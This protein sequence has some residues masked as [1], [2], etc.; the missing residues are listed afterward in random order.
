MRAIMKKKLLFLKIAVIVI[1]VLETIVLA[2]GIIVN[3][4]VDINSSYD[5]IK[6]AYVI[7]QIPFNSFMSSNSEISFIYD[8]I[9]NKI[10]KYPK[11]VPN[12]INLPIDSLSDAIDNDE[13]I[14]IEYADDDNYENGIII[15][16]EPKAGAA[17]DDGIT[18][19]LTINRKY[20]SINSQWG[21]MSESLG[22][23]YFLT[24]AYNSDSGT[25]WADSEKLE[26][27]KMIKLYVDNGN[28]YYN[29][30]G[31]VNKLNEKGALKVLER[32]SLILNYA[33]LNEGIY[34]ID[35]EDG[36]LYHHN[37]KDKTNLPV[38]NMPVMLFSVNTDYIMC[39]SPHDIFVLDA[40]SY[41][42][43]KSMHYK[44]IITGCSLDNDNVYILQY[45]VDD[46]N[47]ESREI[48]KYNIKEDE[49]VTIF[50]SNEGVSGLFAIDDKI[51]FIQYFDD[52]V[53]FR[54]INMRTMEEKF[55]IIKHYDILDIDINDILFDGQRVIYKSDLAFYSISIF[56]GEI[57]KID[58]IS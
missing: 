9:N 26:E 33:V 41:K 53:G 10:S 50:E 31:G 16:Q 57:K 17:W 32:T 3:D 52:R 43:I 20:S 1:L 46:N 36:K 2:G 6:T 23:L 37:M 12:F 19:N 22:K 28:I 8:A 34:Y 58:L 21:Y 25:I 30:R 24:S 14:N 45:K 51:I 27:N 48:T 35:R 11:T 38:T 47:V 13:R 42:V 7:N 44:S 56:T 39:W 29:D 5:A 18:V 55:F 40:K 54:Y 15:S 49:Q 4:I